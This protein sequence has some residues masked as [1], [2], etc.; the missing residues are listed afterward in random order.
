[1]D[2]PD[3]VKKNALILTGGSFYKMIDGDFVF[4]K[5]MHRIVSEN[6]SVQIL[7]AV[8]MEMIFL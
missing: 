1:M 3:V 6:D 4:F 8:P 5:I 7:N 2:F